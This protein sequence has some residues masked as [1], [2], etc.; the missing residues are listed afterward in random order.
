ME[1]LDVTLVMDYGDVQANRVTMKILRVV[2]E[3]D[4]ILDAKLAVLHEGR[5]HP[6]RQVRIAVARNSIVNALDID[7]TR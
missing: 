7:H 6:I 1:P 3:G 2:T 4:E 5:W